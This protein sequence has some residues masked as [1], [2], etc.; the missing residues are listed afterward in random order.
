MS[1]FNTNGGV[2]STGNVKLESYV[3]STNREGFAH[4]DEQA[5]ILNYVQQSN[6]PF[7]LSVSAVAGSGKT[8]TVECVMKQWA[9]MGYGHNTVI[10]TAFN[11]HIAKALKEVGTS[12]KGSGLSGFTSLGG[13]NTASAG[14]RRMI[15]DYVSHNGMTAVDDRDGNK[16][17]NLSRI[18]LSMVSNL[19]SKLIQ[20]TH[21]H[22]T[23]KNEIAGWMAAARGIEKGVVASMAAGIMTDGAEPAL[24]VA[25]LLSGRYGRDE[26]IVFAKEVLG[27]L[28]FADAV[29]SVI[30]DGMKCLN[31]VMGV[32]GY[33]WSNYRRT[34][35]A[36]CVVP[37]SVT[38]YYN[39]RSLVSVR[40]L[41]TQRDGQNVFNTLGMSFGGVP[42]PVAFQDQIYAP[43]ALGLRF[44]TPARLLIVDEVQDF[45]V[46]QGRFLN[47]FID[48]HTS[49]MLVGDIRQSLYL[50]N[51][52][53]SE[54]TRKLVKTYDCVE[55][56]MTICWRNSTS[57]C[58]DV[59]GFMESNMMVADFAGYDLESLKEAGMG[60][61]SAHRVPETWRQ[62]QR[63]VELPAHLLPYAAQHGDLVTCRVNAPLAKLALRTLIDGEKSITLPGGNSGI[64][65]MVMSIVKGNQKHRGAWAGFGLIYGNTAVSM[66]DHD[67]VE[68]VLDGFLD[69]NLEA[70]ER[71]CGGD[72]TAA[73][74]EQRYCDLKDKAEATAEIL[75]GYIDRAGSDNQLASMNGFQS[76]LSNLCGTTE[77]RDGHENTIRFASVHRTKGAQGPTAFVVINKPHEDGTKDTF[78]LDHCMN[79]AP[80]VIQELNACYVAVTRAINRIVYVSYC[81]RLAEAYPTWESFQPVYD[82]LE[83]INIPLSD[84]VRK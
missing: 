30:G 41:M 78:M 83:S 38:G 12:L 17:R 59:R 13:S 31:P 24:D 20:I 45:S 1:G 65:K 70:A 5:N 8:T 52:A 36:D 66:I 22:D 53:D 50:F 40:K 9:N 32:E 71:R 33:G 21:G 25:H 49:I 62:G 28:E 3:P 7:K 77:G 35:T 34:A 4:S 58:Y 72:L 11:N 55:M 27:E 19:E 2:S 74:R 6:L 47:C 37:N 54:A 16:Y 75:H 64:D 15:F 39:S 56:P 29:I 23:I 67:K 48:E 76:W 51:H 10:A 57:V 46:L 14:G 43:V 26:D 44:S 63:F 79:D 68:Y 82:G 84:E 60:D 69:S 42:V 73:K 18:Q 61:Y 81:P 80:E